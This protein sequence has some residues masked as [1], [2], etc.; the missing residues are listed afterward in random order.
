MEKNIKKIKKDAKQGMARDRQEIHG[1]IEVVNV[2]YIIHPIWP[3]CSFHQRREQREQCWTLQGPDSDTDLQGLT[4]MLKCDGWEW[5]LDCSFSTALDLE[6]PCWSQWSH[7]RTVPMQAEIK[8]SEDLSNPRKG[9]GQRKQSKN[10]GRMWA[11]CFTLFEALCLLQ[12]SN[13]IHIY[14]HVFLPQFTPE[15]FFK[16]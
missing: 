4:A 16:Q 2:T 5:V 6:Q 8:S 7:F 3:G 15:I 12:G 9:F 1:V 13:L 10:K 11:L 14:T